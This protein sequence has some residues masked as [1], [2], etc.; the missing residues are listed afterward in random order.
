MSVQ[1][2]ADVV[3]LVE[4]HR[5][6]NEPVDPG[7]GLTWDVGT[8]WEQTLV[9]L[10][11]AVEHARSRGDVVAGLAIDSWGVDFGLVTADGQLAA[12]VRHYRSGTAEA[13]ERAQRAM[14]GRDI[15]GHSGVT[16]MDINTAF[17]LGDAVAACTVPP[18]ELTMLLT[19]DLW[20]YWLTGARGAELTIAG[21]TS[22]LNVTTRVWDLDI[23]HA[24]GLDPRVFPAL[25]EPGSIAGPLLPS[26][27]DRI[28]VN[29]ELP[30]MRTAAHDTAS[31]VAAIPGTGRM[32]FVSAG[33]W[34]LVGVETQAPVLTDEAF[35]AGFPNEIGGAGQILLMRNL[36]GLWLLEQAVA[37]WRRHDP[38][39]TIAGLLAEAEGLADYVSVVDVGDPGLVHSDHVEDHI[40][41]MCAR[42]EQQ[43]PTTPAQLVRCILLSLAV[44][45]RDTLEHCERLTGES[46]DE[47]HMVGGGTRNPLLCQLVA[48][49][50]G[51]PVVIGPAEA[52]SLG[53]ALLQAW[54]RGE[55][56]SAQHI[57]DIVRSS[58]A[59]VLY[60]PRA[61]R[62]AESNPGVH[63]VE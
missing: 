3:T 53:N 63:D 21:T 7:D 50:C 4:E 60:S 62:L 2:A 58:Y 6:A 14:S 13:L 46:F 41:R 11:R 12:P 45:F 48:D 30:V 20:T 10:E 47:V 24:L 19:P 8:L 5:F 32:A 33:T 40:R 27:A 25:A 23:A 61:T 9:G 52:T 18:D 15:F 39:I 1:L 56:E 28:G 49:M 36:T 43:V 35:T 34:A 37:Q 29:Q 22:L 59:P 57:R 16:P 55:V 31:A 44:A 54:G 42:T 26:L 38:S 17:R 51:K